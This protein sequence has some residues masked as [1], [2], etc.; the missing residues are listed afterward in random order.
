M[1]R[2]EL[3]QGHNHAKMCKKSGT[4]TPERIYDRMNS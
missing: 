2:S 3:Q 1:F 4:H